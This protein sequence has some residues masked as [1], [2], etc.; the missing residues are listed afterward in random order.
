[1]RPEYS[2][3]EVLA[4]WLLVLFAQGLLN[5]GNRFLIGRTAERLLARLRTSLYDHIQALPLRY[6]DE[7]RRGEMLALLTY[8]A[9]VL[10]SFVTGPLLNLLPQFVILVGALWFIFLIDHKLVLLI[11]AFVPLLFLLIKILGRSVRPLSSAIIDEY[12]R[13]YALADE[14]LQMLPAI[15]SFTREEIESERFRRC[16]QRLLGLNTHYLR[17]QS[18]LSPLIHFLAALAIL[19]LLWLSSARL[20]A[21][22]LSS[23]E[24]VS[25]LLYSLLLARPVSSL[26]DLYGQIQHARGALQRLTGIFAIN[27]EPE[28]TDQNRLPPVTGEIEFQGVEFSYPGREKVLCGVNLFIKAGETLAITGAN[29]CGKSTLVH[30]LQRFLEPD[31]GRILIDGMDIARFGLRSLRSQIGVVQQDMLLLNGTVRE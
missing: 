26:A 7:K 8:D 1:S 20:Q 24:L 29:G 23:A 15:K 2:Y 14:N 22:H 12:A 10:S 3:H 9:D 11:A 16:N 4:L 30:L 28:D 13:M 27:P 18:M 25:L 31:Q 17:I 21:G 19:V 6:F 5:F